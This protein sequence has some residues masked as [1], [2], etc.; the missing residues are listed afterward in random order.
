MRKC[1]LSKNYTTVTSAG[2]KAKT[3]IEEI[4][5]AEGFMNIGIQQARSKNK[6]K[7]FFITLAS[8]LKSIVLLKK[9]DVLLMQYP[10]K[11]YY[12][13]VCKMAH[14]KGVRVITIIHDLGSF[15]RKKLS[16]EEER[17]LLA[18]SDYLITG[19]TVMRQWL[20]DNDHQ[21]PIAVLGAWDYLSSASPKQTDDKEKFNSIVHAGSLSPEKHSYIYKL[22][23]ALSEQAS[24]RFDIYGGDLDMNK[25]VNKSLFTY[26][27]FTLPD[28]LIANIAGDFG[29]IWY[30]HSI[31]EIDGV[32]G[33]YFKINTAHKLSLYIRCHLPIIVW[34]KMAMAQFVKEHN[35]GFT[36]DSLTELEEK[37]NSLSKHDYLQMKHNTVAI[38]NRIA[39]GRSFMDAYNELIK[40]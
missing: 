30:G 27:G 25:I 36:V 33:E 4:I 1:Y 19:N 3:D 17:K 39:K 37:I 35:I 2:N 12:A 38:S 21:Q 5:A 26:H 14:L 24:I 40:N 31:D 16:I 8:V 10:L 34:S 11:K 23:E 9:G 13:F 29:L 22:D 15:R 7:G 18:N 20:K 32:W 28:N 6:L